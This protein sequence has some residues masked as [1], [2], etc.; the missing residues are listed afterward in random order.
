M[1]ESLGKSDDYEVHVALPREGWL[2]EQLIHTKAQFHFIGHPTL[3]S[4]EGLSY[5]LRFIFQSVRAIWKFYRFCKQLRP[6]LVHLNTSVSPFAL[7][8]AKLLGIPII[9]HYR[10]KPGRPLIFKALNLLNAVFA[11]GFISN[12]QF[13]KNSLAFGYDKTTVFYDASDMPEKITGPAG[14]KHILVIT[15]FSED[16][17]LDLDLDVLSLILQKVPDAHMDVVGGVIDRHEHFAREIQRRISEPPLAGKV[18]L[19]GWQED[20]ISFMENVDMLLHL[21]K[22][23]ETFGLILV[24]ACAHGLP[25]VA[26]NKGGMP[27]I[28][29]NGANGFLVEDGD[30]SGA[31]D[32]CIELLTH[33]RLTREM[34]KA[35]RK[36]VEEGFSPAQED[37][38]IRELYDAF[39][40]N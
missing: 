17:G 3:T 6:D 14:D 40:R 23:E 16:K 19:H 39:R 9:V 33:L 31:A 34:G 27:E 29:Q 8:G 15:R 10:E 38:K 7:I 26:F 12:S 28:V 35:G 18:T 24:E 30:V 5:Q 37:L 2:T 20:L 11:D 4:R 32:R 13:M 22:V 25:C 36:K 1:A 21:P